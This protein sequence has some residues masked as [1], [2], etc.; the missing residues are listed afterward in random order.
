MDCVFLVSDESYH[1]ASSS[2]A[3]NMSQGYFIEL[4]KLVPGSYKVQA[5]MQAPERIPPALGGRLRWV[6]TS[7]EVTLL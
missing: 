7:V 4:D 2:R 3:R 6:S 1:V 5:P